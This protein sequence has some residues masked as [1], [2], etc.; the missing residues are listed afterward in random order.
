MSVLEKERRV[1]MP[2]PRSVMGRTVFALARVESRRLLLHPLVV[3]AVLGYVTLLMWP[4]GAGEEVFPVLHEV[5]RETQLGALMIGFAGL[6]A[7]NAAVLRSRRHGTEAHF[8]VLVLPGWR[9]TVAHALSLVPLALVA[10]LVIGG[11]FAREALRPGAVGPVPVSELLTGPL[12]VLLFGGLGVMLARLVRSVLAGPLAVVVLIAITFVFV[13]EPGGLRWLAPLVAGEGARPLP[14]DLVGRPAGWHVLYLAGLAL[15][16]VLV[17][18]MVSG[19]RTVAI[20]ATA[21]GALAV[22]LV[23]ATMQVQGPSAELVAAREQATNEPA[24]VQDC[25]R[26]MPT[27]YCA[28]PEFKPWIGEWRQVAEGVR[29]LAG[30]PAATRELTVRQQVYA[31]DGPSGMR[32]LPPASPGEVT[33]GT[34]WDGERRLEF[35]ASF[36]RGLVVND[37]SESGVYCDARGIVMMWM[38]ISGIPDGEAQ[39]GEARAAIA[40]AGGMGMIAAPVSPLVV[41]DREYAVVKAMLDRPTAEMA[42]KVKASWAELVRPSTTP[43]RAAALLGVTVPAEAAVDRDWKCA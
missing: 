21:A 13:S 6:V 5:G 8:G 39:H 16:L 33:V 31:L 7:V 36:A 10:V 34:A 29:S 17:A 35:A 22:T 11:G 23:G 26:R 18:V 14:A 40:G 20:R 3:L 38:A 9:R 30:A 27:T 12:L 41:R 37:E 42:A 19:G 32:G 4:K 25:E 1:P 43:D 24:S 2:V 15:L 28:F